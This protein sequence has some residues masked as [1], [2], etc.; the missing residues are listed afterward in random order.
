VEPW[1]VLVGVDFATICVP[2]SLRV[3]RR[4]ISQTGS[5]ISGSRPTKVPFRL[6]RQHHIRWRERTVTTLV[7]SLN[8]R[9]K[10]SVDANRR[11]FLSRQVYKGHAK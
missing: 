11:T 4:L 5:N 6:R 8:A 1:S 2:Q 9:G 7:R 3:R 10:H